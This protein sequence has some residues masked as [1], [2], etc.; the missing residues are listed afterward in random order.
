MD[1]VG[2]LIAAIEA[3]GL[4]RVRIAADAGMTPE[5]LSKILTRRQIPTVPEFIAIARASMLDPGRLFTDSELVVEV[6][7][8]RAVQALS[9]E[10][11]AATERLD[12]LLT[13]LLPELQAPRTS[14]TALPKPRRPQSA[15]PILAAADPNAEMVVEFERERKQIPRDAWNRGAHIIARVVGDSMDG[16]DDPIADGELAYLKPTRSKKTA[17][18]KVALVRREDGLYLKKFEQS[19]HTIRLVS[20]NTSRETIVIDARA[21]AVQIY[22]YVVHHAPETKSAAPAS[23]A[24][25]RV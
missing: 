15:Q 11:R 25:R 13:E 20:A 8:I 19:G 17:S 16:G 12:Q 10:A 24:D 21:D 18:G 23:Q 1:V 3:S 2:R 22:G 4:K 9:R 5:K 6:D 14:I 7:T